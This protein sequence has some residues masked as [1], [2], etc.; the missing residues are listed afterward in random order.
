MKKT[1]LATIVLLLLGSNNARAVELSIGFNTWYSWWQPAWQ[2]GIFKEPLP[3][4]YLEAMFSDYPDFKTDSSFMY[5][6]TVSL[7]FFGK[8][9]ISS[10]FMYGRYTSRDI[11]IVPWTHNYVSWN[12]DYFRSKRAIEKYDSD[13]ILS[14]SPVSFLKIF[15]GFKYQGY[16]YEEDALRPNDDFTNGYIVSGKNTIKN[17]GTGLGVGFT[18]PVVQNLFWIV[19]I[20]GTILWG[21][22]KA[23]FDPLIVFSGGFFPVWFPNGRFIAYGGNA[24]TSFAY[25]IEKISTTISIGFRYQ[26][27]KYY[28]T[29][30]MTGFMKMGGSFDH[31]YG[32][33]CS[34]V[35]TLDFKKMKSKKDK[36]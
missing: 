17:Y 30:G 13:T 2:K 1:V 31:F 21:T 15:T 24:S 5:G 23:I 16:T 25:F 9:G 36:G 22:E 29:T 10:T 33:T 27:L 34:V 11:G 26:A 14:F 18:V 32:A 6:P 28:Q 7:K 20:S 3:G 4:P 19:N 35:Y 12:Y 8:L